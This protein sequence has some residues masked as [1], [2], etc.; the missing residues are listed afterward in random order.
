MCSW[1]L[2]LWPVHTVSVTIF[3]GPLS[4]SLLPVQRPYYAGTGYRARLLTL[5]H[6]TLSLVPHRSGPAA[7]SR[8]L[9]RLECVASS[10]AVASSRHCSGFCPFWRSERCSLHQR[11]SLVQ[12]GEP[13]PSCATRIRTGCQHYSVVACF[14]FVLLFLFRATDGRLIRPPSPPCDSR[15]VAAANQQNNTACGF[16]PQDELALLDRELYSGTSPPH[17]P[18]KYN[19]TEQNAHTVLPET[20]HLPL[21]P[22]TPASIAPPAA[23]TPHNASAH[24]SPH[25]HPRP[26]SALTLCIL[27]STVLK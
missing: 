8:K 10:L 21:K 19:T 3:N 14:T 16:C 9:I 27:S 2:A 6:S 20:A 7:A 11:A 15:A 5:V 26:S 25:P 1:H 17:L 24:D 18:L 12:R 13:L 22:I 4:P 23:H